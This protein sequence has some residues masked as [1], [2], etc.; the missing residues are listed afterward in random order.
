VRTCTGGTWSFED[1]TADGFSL[2]TQVGGSADGIA[3]STTRASDGT[4]SL[5]IATTFNCSRTA[6]QVV[7]YPCG[8][9]TPVNFAGKTLTFKVYFD[10]PAFLQ[11]PV[12]PAVTIY[13]NPARTVAITPAVNT[14]ISVSIPLG[15]SDSSDDGI[16]FSTFMQTTGP[17]P[18]YLCGSWT[19]T[20]YLDGFSV[21]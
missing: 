21:Q 17:A 1:G 19:G 3:V 14:W 6:F 8:L 7:K 12:E 9:G 16:S 5:A 20:V 10:G 11:G 13:S 18:S 15:A 2:A 4:H